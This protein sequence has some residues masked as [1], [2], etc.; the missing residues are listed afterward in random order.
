MENLQV[1]KLMFNKILITAEQFSS[2]I[3]LTADDK[4]TKTLK[5]VQTVVATGPFANAEG[6]NIK[7]GDKVVIDPSHLKASTYAF[8]K[9]TGEY[10]SYGTNVDKEDLV[11]LLMITDRDIAMVLKK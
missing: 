4:N 6:S 2:S 9:D 11:F 3:I 1:E 10:V 8:R 5:E 7:V